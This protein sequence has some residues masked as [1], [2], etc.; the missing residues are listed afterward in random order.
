MSFNVKNEMKKL[1]EEK[2]QKIVELIKKED[3]DI[4]GLQEL[5]YNLKKKLEKE[6]KTYHFFGRSR[7]CL[8]TFF[9]EYNSILV[10]RN[11]EVFEVNTYSLG[12]RP[13]KVRSK[14]I[15]SV[16]PR[17]CTSIVCV[18]NDKKIKVMNTHLD[19]FHAKTKK[20]QLS[21]IK[22]ILKNNTYPFIIMGD[23]N[24]YSSTAHL[25][26]FARSMN[27]TDIF[28]N[29]GRTRNESPKDKP[30]DHIF[31]G[32]EFIYSNNRIIDSDISDHYPIACEIEIK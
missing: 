1:K 18:L 13:D 11:V 17:I 26:D 29:E 9:D 12:R 7:F 31:I 4:I 22:K 30:I 28:A 25:K 19:N 20:Y 8:N 32:K 27:L 6:L 15:L 2:I 10:K 3:P 24:M 23:F 21:V 14:N 16:F 5:T